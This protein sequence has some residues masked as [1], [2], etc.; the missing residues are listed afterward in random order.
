MVAGAV[1]EYLGLVLQPAKGAGMDDA[2]AV[3]LEVSTPLRRF[4]A[5]F[6][7]TGSVAE[8]CVR[9]QEL[10]LYRRSEKEGFERRSLG[11][12]SFVPLL[13]GTS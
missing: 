7:A 2:I 13:G 6:A 12:V 11:P 8:L 1:E 9:R 5:V 3:A 10:V 4:L